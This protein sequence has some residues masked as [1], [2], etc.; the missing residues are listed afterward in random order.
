M[1]ETLAGNIAQGN[2]YL[3]GPGV[4]EGQIPKGDATNISGEI[5]AANNSGSKIAF[6]SGTRV[7]NVDAPGDGGKEDRD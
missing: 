1:S 3:P 4:T 7:V 5:K 2:N 6:P